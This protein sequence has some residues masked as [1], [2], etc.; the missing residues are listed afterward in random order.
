MNTNFVSQVSRTIKAHGL[1]DM[2]DRIL[3]G[4][5]GGADSVALL[6]ALL[7]LR[8]DCEAVHC[9]FHLRG[10]ESDRDERFVQDLCRRLKVQLHVTHFDTRTYAR[11]HGVSIEMAAREQRYAYFNRLLD[12]LGMQKIAV[13]HHRDDNVETMMLNLVRGTGLKGLTGMR[14]L[15]GRIIRPLLD[16]S[17]A[18]IEHYLQQLQ[19]GYVTDST[20]F[21]E[22]VQRN[23]VRL[24][25]LPMLR[26][27]NPAVMETLQ[28]TI[29]RLEESYA[30]YADSISAWKRRACAGDVIDMD[31]LLQSPSPRTLLYELL[32]EYGFGSQQCQDIYERI[33]AGPGKVYESDGWRLLRDRNR[34]LL[35]RKGEGIRCLTPVLPLDGVVQIT[36]TMM[37]SISRS[38]IGRDFRIPT[39]PST[40]CLDLDRL[41]YPLTLRT[42]QTGDRFV[43]LGMEGEKLVSDYLTDRKMNAF[44]KENQLVMCSGNRIAWLVGQRID[45]RFKID[46][47]TTRVITLV[48]Y[49]K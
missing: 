37:L 38:S 45:N 43:P 12:E 15:N 17:K 9:N 27:L 5:S 2:R 39:D 3:V 6:H 26:E 11:V 40:A 35:R 48:A 1:V 36:P 30:F 44:D 32:G 41:Q 10:E 33:G 42:Y 7:A 20:N 19:V 8:V 4:L 31:V 47:H 22:D 16:V 25:V 21:E 13:A 14:H 18:D 23:V 46:E 28:A 34:L 49:A 24:R 29:G